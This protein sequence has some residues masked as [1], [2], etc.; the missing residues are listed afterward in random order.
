MRLRSVLPFG[1]VVF[2]SGCGLGGSGAPRPEL[3]VEIVRLGGPAK[4]DRPAYE[5]EVL[6]PK[7]STDSV[8]PPEKLMG[9]LGLALEPALDVCWATTSDL[10]L[11]EAAI[12]VAELRLDGEGKARL[13][14]PPAAPE[15]ARCITDRFDGAA[16]FPPYAVPGGIPLGL[17]FV[18]EDLT[19]PAASDEVV[20][21]QVI[22]A[23]TADEPESEATQGGAPAE[24]PA[25][26]PA[27]ADP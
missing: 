21:G 19:A 24:A 18:E 14:S 11:D 25:A 1:L 13:V 2:I 17:R 8:L 10:A 23:A 16:G 3:Q 26:E 20:Q 5:V 27:R 4:G 15:L 6:V 9:A 22:D 7:G 12:V